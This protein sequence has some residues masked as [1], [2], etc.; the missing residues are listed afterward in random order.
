[1]KIIDSAYHPRV[2]NF[3]AYTRI[4]GLLKNSLIIEFCV[5]EKYNRLT[6]G[7]GKKELYTTFF[8]NKLLKKRQLIKGQGFYYRF[9]DNNNRK[10]Y[11]MLIL[12]DAYN[13]IEIRYE[14]PSPPKIVIKHKYFD[15]FIAFVESIPVEDLEPD[16]FCG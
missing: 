11:I 13:D 4:T 16:P 3:P 6:I 10:F 14:W 2:L 1:M 15:K 7:D 8:F 5:R 9:I 12:R